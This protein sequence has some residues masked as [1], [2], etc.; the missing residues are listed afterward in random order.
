MQHVRATEQQLRQIIREIILEGRADFEQATQDIEYAADFED[1][2]FHRPKMRKYIEPA[3]KVKQ[4]WAM[5]VD[6]IE[7]DEYVE[8]EKPAKLS[9]AR[10][11]IQSLH[12]VTWMPYRGD[13]LANLIKFLDDTD[14][15]GEIACALTVPGRPMEMIAGWS[16]LGVEVDGW[17]TLAAENMN[18]LLTGYIGQVPR[19]QHYRYEHSGVP[20]R[21]TVF[22]PELGSKYIFGPED[23]V[24]LLA[25]EDRE[26][27]SEALVAN[28]TPKR[29]VIDY[30]TATG[31]LLD[32]EY[33]NPGS[34]IGP[35]LDL[36]KHKIKLP[37]VDR[38][39]M[40]IDLKKMEADARYMLD[41]N[42]V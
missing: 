30:D 8:G 32:G 29:I 24:K 15:R 19:Y 34:T 33:Q 37:I 17:V 21:P 26:G 11:W 5:A 9:R 22:N 18:A 12:K 42:N 13:V 25:P 2:L 39:G 20:R 35:F 27:D 4:A 14:R 16:W 38:I 41:P 10:Q 36:M 3:R 6:K 1:P 23:E 28:W 7:P 40:P 31:Y